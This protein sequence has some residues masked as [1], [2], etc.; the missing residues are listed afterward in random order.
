MLSIATMGPVGSDSYNAAKQYNPEADLVCFNSM[1]EL[2]T[3]FQAGKSEY[4]LI[5]V[6]NTREGEIKEYF[7]SLV[8]LGDYYCYRR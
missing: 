2:V 6:Y 3:A 5:P 4:A 1:Y 8:G 7:R